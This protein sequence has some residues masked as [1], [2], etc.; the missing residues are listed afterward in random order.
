MIENKVGPIGPRKFPQN[1]SAFRARLQSQLSERSYL[2]LRNTIR[3]GLA[4][5]WLDGSRI[6][7][8]CG[9][10]IE[11]AFSKVLGGE[12]RVR[13]GK[14]FLSVAEE[15]LG[16]EARFDICAFVL[17]SGGVLLRLPVA[18][19]VVKLLDR[20]DERVELVKL[21]FSRAIDEW[22]GSRLDEA[23]E[24]AKHL[25]QNDFGGMWPNLQKI[26]SI[27]N[28]AVEKMENKS[29]NASF[30]EE[31]SGPLITREEIEE[32]WQRAFHG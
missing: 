25:D 6:R 13:I 14:E 31:Q 9:N 19:D 10:G 24:F 32:I 1:E 12:E 23:L 21:V 30:G 22:W 27:L 20:I 11:E 2:E 16:K 29:E 4:N 18:S 8:Y 26:L 5:K 7:I 17:E 3:E 28:Q 15:F